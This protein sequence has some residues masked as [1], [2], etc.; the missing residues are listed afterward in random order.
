MTKMDD[1]SDVKDEGKQ[2]LHA[3]S[4]VG[5]WNVTILLENNLV[6]PNKIKKHIYSLTQQSHSWMAELQKQNHKD[7][8][9]R[10]TVL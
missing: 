10:I 7:V 9:R 3:Y 6:L 8:C 1:T 5:V 2:A 4:A